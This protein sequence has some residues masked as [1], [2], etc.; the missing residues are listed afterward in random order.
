V[1]SGALVVRGAVQVVA[2]VATRLRVLGAEELAP[3][4][5]PDWQKQRAASD[6]LRHA[7]IARPTCISDIFSISTVD[8]VCYPRKPFL[9][10]PRL[11]LNRL[12]LPARRNGRNVFSP[13][14]AA[15]RRVWQKTVPPGALAGSV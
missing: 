10:V 1:G 11:P 12:R 2:A 8:W 4:S 9:L 13:R 6:R 7:R 15:R 5:L 14:G 3:Q